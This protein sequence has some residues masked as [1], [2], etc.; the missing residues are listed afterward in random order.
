VLGDDIWVL[1]EELFVCQDT[2][3]PEAVIAHGVTGIALH[4]VKWIS[5]D[6]RPI[7]LARIGWH[8][9]TLYALQLNSVGHAVLF[10]CPAE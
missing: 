1:S 10:R 7:D 4:G 8:A 2:G 5:K 9:P 3:Q 6:G